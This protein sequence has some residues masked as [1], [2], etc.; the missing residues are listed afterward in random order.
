MIEC[1]TVGGHIQG[2]PCIFP[3]NFKGKT[4]F[5]CTEMVKDVDGNSLPQCPT[6]KDFLV[7]SIPYYWGNCGTNCPGSPERIIRGT[8]KRNF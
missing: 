2:E 1:K 4:Y 7:D 5:Q 3:F 8:G 6:K